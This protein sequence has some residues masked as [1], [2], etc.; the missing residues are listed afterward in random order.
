ME[1][2]KPMHSDWLLKLRISFAIHFRV[3]RARFVPKNIL[4]VAGINE[5]KFTLYAILTHSFIMY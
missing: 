4:I 3:T 1:K 5:F 2:N